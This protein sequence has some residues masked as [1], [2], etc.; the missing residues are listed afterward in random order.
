MDMVSI[1]G[2]CKPQSVN[3]AVLW[4][5]V[6]LSVVHIIKET[7]EF[8][9]ETELRIAGQQNYSNISVNLKEHT[10]WNTTTGRKDY[11]YS[12]MTMIRQML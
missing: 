5:P 10:P 1:Y 11:C 4:L 12:H 2:R 6:R 8:I 9:F 3:V 7:A